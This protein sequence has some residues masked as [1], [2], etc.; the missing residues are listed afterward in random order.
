MAESSNSNLYE[1][2]YER[3]RDMLL[4]GELRP[5]SRIS[6]LDLSKQ[7]RIS[8]TPVRAEL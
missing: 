5:G 7:L 8:R 2:A 4:Q 3:I 1:E 6:G